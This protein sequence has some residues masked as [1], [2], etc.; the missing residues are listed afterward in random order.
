MILALY[1]CETPITHDARGDDSDNGPPPVDTDTGGAGETG[2]TGS[3]EIAPTWGNWS[4]T[5]ASVTSD[6]C[7]LAD[8]FP[9]EAGDQVTVVE[10]ADPAFELSHPQGVEQCA[11]DAVT[12]AFTCDEH[13]ENDT[14]IGESLGYDVSLTITASLGGTFTDADHLGM[15]RAYYV[16]CQGDACVTMEAEVGELPCDMAMHS[17]AEAPEG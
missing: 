11:L 8:Y 9:H 2:E 13:V 15:D 7:N 12:G 17:D 4:I 16:I 1:A 6:T 3:A 5:G 10:G 14:A